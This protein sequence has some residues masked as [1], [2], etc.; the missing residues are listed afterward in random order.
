MIRIFCDFCEKETAE[1]FKSAGVDLTHDGYEGAIH[2]K[3]EGWPRGELTKDGHICQACVLKHITQLLGPMEDL[4]P[5]QL[6]ADSTRERLIAEIGQC[7]DAHRSGNASDSGFIEN[8]L[9]LFDSPEY[10]PVTNLIPLAPQEAPFSAD[11]DNGYGFGL[12][13]PVVEGREP[14]EDDDIPF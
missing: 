9:N 4:T 8:V 12:D 11:V 13:V 2:I 6:P 10:R 3:A 14:G 1:P 5:V 7:I